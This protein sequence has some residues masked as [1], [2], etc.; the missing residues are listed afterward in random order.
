VFPIENIKMLCRQRGITIAELE[1]NLGFGNGSISYWAKSSPPYNRLQ[2]VAEYLGV[3]V[4]KLAGEEEP[5]TNGDELIEILEACK[6]RSDLRGLFKLAKNST[7]ED[8]RKAMAI[9]EA[10]KNV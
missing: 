3:S 4:Q 7:P 2:M 5:P 10:L 8:V 9:F 6:D 1:R